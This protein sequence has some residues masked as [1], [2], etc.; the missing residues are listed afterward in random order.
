MAKLFAIFSAI[1]EGVKIFNLR[2]AMYD[3]Y[4]DKKIDKHYE[5]KKK[6]RARIV[7]QVELESAKE[8]PDDAILRDLHYKLNNLKSNVL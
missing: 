6:R 3:K 8:S 2:I 1:K 7:S 4:Q 5:N